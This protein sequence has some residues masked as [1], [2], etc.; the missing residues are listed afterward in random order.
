[1][2][3]GAC[4]CVFVLGLLVVRSFEMR[5][6]K[7]RW[8]EQ[9]FYDFRALLSEMCKSPRSITE[10]REMRSLGRFADKSYREMVGPLANAATN[11]VLVRN[12]LATKTK[13]VANK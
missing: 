10:W 1:M 5:R 3:F 9:E 11:E 4:F 7:T 6:E 13:Q 8:V 2:G 12:L